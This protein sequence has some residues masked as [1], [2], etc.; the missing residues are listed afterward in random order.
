MWMLGSFL[1]FA[2]GRVLGAEIT[3]SQGLSLSLS[4][5]L[6]LCTTAGVLGVFVG[7]ASDQLSLSSSP[8]R[9]RL[10]G[11]APQL[12]RTHHLDHS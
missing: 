6:S 10:L 12:G 3:F 8:G 7:W 1:I 4:L 2:L 9:H 5:S 11:A